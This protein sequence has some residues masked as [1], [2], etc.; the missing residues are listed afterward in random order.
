MNGRSGALPSTPVRSGA[1]PLAALLG[2]GPRQALHPIEQHPGA[3]QVRQA[4]G[5]V[6][7]II[8]TSLAGHLQLS[9]VPEVLAEGLGV[10]PNTPPSDQ[11]EQEVDT[12]AGNTERTPVS[13]EPF[14]LPPL[15]PWP[16]DLPS[17]AESLAAF[18]P[19]FKTEDADH[20]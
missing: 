18:E 6:T 9:M 2:Q 14:K 7:L 16:D 13:P 3:V 1:D 17:V 12:A 8:P 5:R 11:Q 15:P 19:R 10:D 20:G 4:D